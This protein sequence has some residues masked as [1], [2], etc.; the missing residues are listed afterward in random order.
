[1]LRYAD[2]AMMLI[3]Q[4][5]IDAAAV[6]AAIRHVTETTAAADFHYFFRRLMS[7]L[8]FSSFISITT[9]ILISSPSFF[10]SSDAFFEYHIMS[11]AARCLRH[12]TPLR[13]AYFSPHFHAAADTLRLFR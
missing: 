2:R 8:I 11:P 4:Y 13:H 12:V 1:M 5:A 9:S 10:F 3:Q 7:S 6:D